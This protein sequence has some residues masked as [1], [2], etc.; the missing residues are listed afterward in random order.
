MPRLKDALSRIT[1]TLI[2]ALALSASAAQPVTKPIEAKPAP[3]PIDDLAEGK[4]LRSAWAGAQY[5]FTPD[6]R[7]AYLA[8]AKAQTRHALAAAGKRF[9]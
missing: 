4:A 1:L 2:A 3:L 6:V 9:R 5:K 7:A 8:F